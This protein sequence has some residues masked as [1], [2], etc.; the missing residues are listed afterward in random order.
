MEQRYESEQS[1]LKMFVSLHAC[2]QEYVI[3]KYVCVFSVC[4]H[5]SYTVCT[6][7]GSHLIDQHS[8]CPFTIGNLELTLYLS[9]LGR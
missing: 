9:N 6:C 7:V 4:S 8:Y 3:Y 2:V 5:L 1:L